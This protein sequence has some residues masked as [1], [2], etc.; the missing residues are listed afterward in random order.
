MGSPGV[1]TAAGTAVLVYLVLSG[2]L[3]GDGAGADGGRG[4][5]EVEMISSAVS[6]A[7]AA[8]ERRKE[9]ARARRRARRGRRW[10]ERA[11]QG[12]GE[13]VVEAAKTVRFAYGETLGKWSLGELAFGI[14]YYMRQQGNLQH[15]YA[16]S[17]SVPQGGPRARE[18][19]ISLLR[20]MKLCMYFSKKPYKVFLEFGGY[21]KSDV[22]I[23]KSKARFLKPAFTVV[24]ERSSKCFLLFIRGA[25]SVKE[26]L[27]AATGADIPF[28]H[29]VAKGGRVSN[30]VLGYAHCGMATS[31]R[32]IAGQATPC[33]SKAAAQFPD[34]R[35]M[36]IGHSMGASIAAL[37][38]CILRENDRLSSSTCIA[39]GPAACMTWDLAESCKDFITTIVN[40]NDVVPSLGRVS[41]AKLRTEVMAS[42]WVHELREQIQQT[43]FLGF[44]NRSVSFMRAHVPF[45][46]DPR[47]KIVDAN[48]L[49]PYTS[50][51]EIKPSED[52]H[53]E[54]KKRP[55]LVCWSCGSA[56]KQAIDPEKHTRDMTNETDV[57]DR[58]EKSDT[59]AAAQKLA[60]VSLGASDDEDTN[61]EDNKSPPI[62]TDEG[63]A[64]EFQESLTSKQQELPPS[65]P[66]EDSLQLY[67]PGRILHMVALPAAEPNTSQ[68]GGQ[69]EV[70]TLYETPR[71]LYSKIRLGKSMVGEH[72]MPKYIK[73]ME[74]LIE[75]L[76]GEDIDGDQLEFL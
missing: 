39:F 1:A 22:L 38:T 54:V 58:T 33:L 21:D 47:S 75:K 2:R 51:A 16:G 52:I 14:N 26:R 19:L 62:G 32:W 69:E 36:I 44:V 63:Q 15:E 60:S 72:Y 49:Q 74:L 10:P 71:H 24:R 20:Y 43:R 7:A 55:S 23:K 5:M 11:P 61:R 46:S 6:T 4:A 68:Q 70:V 76:A 31:A 66:S 12:W 45:V 13:A 34:Y 8:R 40:R 48:M 64:M 28:H 37:L 41:T 29:V 56:Q 18:E 57:D 53:C 17:D 59:E 42:S 65:G 3:C 9:E 50:E 67:P 35:I 73:T 25:I 30:L 27:T